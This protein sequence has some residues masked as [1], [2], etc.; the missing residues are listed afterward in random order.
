VL[1]S[2]RLLRARHGLRPFLNRKLD[3]DIFDMGLDGFW[4]DADDARDLL[5]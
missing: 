5:V 2:P 1:T 3:E 4:C